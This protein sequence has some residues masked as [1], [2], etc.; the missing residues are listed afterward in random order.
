MKELKTVDE[1]IQAVRNQ[2]LVLNETHDFS[3]GR[4]DHVFRGKLESGSHYNVQI[5]DREKIIELK[6]VIQLNYNAQYS[7]FSDFK[8]FAD[9]KQGNKY[10]LVIQGEFGFLNAIQ[11]TFEAVNFAKYAQY[12]DSAALIFLP[13]RKR[14]LRQIQFYGNKSFILW[15]GWQNPDTEIFG[16]ST[17]KSEG[18]PFSI[19]VSKSKY[20]SFDSG[21]LEDALKSVPVAPLISRFPEKVEGKRHA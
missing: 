3:N 8:K 10:T 16:R 11:F 6:Q 12:N 5:F 2:K 20:S 7:Q 4:N 15:E 9:L 18:G 14:K 13:K 19:T 17:P 1:I 21:Y